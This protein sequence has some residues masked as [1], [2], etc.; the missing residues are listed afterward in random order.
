MISTISFISAFLTIFSLVST[1]SKLGVIAISLTTF[2]Y[3]CTKRI[4][5]RRLTPS[6]SMCI[7]T[8]LACSA[9]SCKPERVSRSLQ[10]ASSGILSS[11]ASFPKYAS[12]LAPLRSARK[13]AET[14]STFDSAMLA[15]AA[16]TSLKALFAAFAAREQLLNHFC[17]V[18]FASNT[19]PFTAFLIASSSCC[20]FIAAFASSMAAFKT[21]S[22]ALASS[23]MLTGVANS[24]S[25]AGVA[26][27][28]ARGLHTSSIF[29]HCASIAST[30]GFATSRIASASFCSFASI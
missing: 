29:L 26:S 30:A 1:I 24:E 8:S 22:T 17:N 12:T 7:V 4:K 19:G 10:K 11:F 2:I 15:H 9:G 20:F 6:E 28:S 18:F 21:T 25:S 27:F 3:S 23:V 5:A 16:F 14:L 13:A